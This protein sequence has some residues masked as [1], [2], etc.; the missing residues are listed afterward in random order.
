MISDQDY[1][2]VEFCSTRETTGKNLLSKLS[3]K[4]PTLIVDHQVSALLDTCVQKFN[5]VDARSI[6]TSN[7]KCPFSF[8]SKAGAHQRDPLGR[9]STPTVVKANQTQRS[10]RQ[11]KYD[12][13]RGKNLF[14]KINLLGKGL[15][16]GI[17][18]DRGSP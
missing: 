16:Q 11:G 6:V 13:F 2:R 18:G 15:T 1:C 3:F 10:Q 8:K 14:L 12:T 17:S 5:K 9:S 4:L 7:A